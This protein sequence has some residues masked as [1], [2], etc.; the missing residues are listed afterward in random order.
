MNKVTL[1][2]WIVQ[3]VDRLNQ[4]DANARADIE[5]LATILRDMDALL[6]Q[7]VLQQY[8]QTRQDTEVVQKALVTHTTEETQKILGE[9]AL[10]KT[11]CLVSDLP[12]TRC[13]YDSSR[14]TTK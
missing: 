2:S 3:Q 10:I 11:R 7:V 9:I 14:C 1:N 6:T 13:P 5:H 12:V 4:L 8:S